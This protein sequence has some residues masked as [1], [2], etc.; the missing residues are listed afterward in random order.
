MQILREEDTSPTHKEDRHLEQHVTITT[1]TDSRRSGRKSC[2]ELCNMC[3]I[4]Q[5]PRS[6]FCFH[7]KSYSLFYL[8]FL[9]WRIFRRPT[10]TLLWRHGAL[11]ACRLAST[12]QRMLPHHH[13]FLIVWLVHSPIDQVPH[14]VRYAWHHVQVDSIDHTSK[15]G[16]TRS[17][18]VFAV[19][20]TDTAA[21]QYNCSNNLRNIGTC[22]SQDF[23]CIPLGCFL[24]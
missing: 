3:K 6:S 2:L 4:T 1:T 19:V 12:Y 18:G 8:I 10:W 23:L 15:V 11:C 17:K 5:W 16:Q 9:Y 24:R 20:N 22:E 21:F 14:I 13:S 7:Y